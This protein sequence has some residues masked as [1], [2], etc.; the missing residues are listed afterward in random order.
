M[1]LAELPQAWNAGMQTML[2]L[3]PPTDREGCLQDLHWYDGAWGYF[4][5]YSLGAMAAA[6]LYAAAVTADPA[7][8][9]GIPAGDF[10]PLVA[11]LR[12]HVHS[13]GSL[14]SA[15]DLLLQS[16][17]RPLDPEAFKT[18]LKSRYLG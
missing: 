17:G 4:P 6:Q 7:I 16:T 13:R 18:H 8:P 9:D 3:T 5:T 15:P 14:L 11:W 1:P 10:R 2:G 12:A